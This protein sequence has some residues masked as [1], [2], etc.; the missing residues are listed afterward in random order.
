MTRILT[1]IAASAALVVS[2]AVSCGP[3]QSYEYPYQ[4]PKLTIEERVENLMS[5]LTPEEKAFLGR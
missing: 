4:N 1:R 2:L 5:L 3:K